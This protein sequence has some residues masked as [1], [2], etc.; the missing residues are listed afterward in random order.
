MKVINETHWR[1]DHLR[2]FILRVAK[3]ELPTDALPRTIVKVG[4][5]R[6][7]SG[8]A[9]RAR[10]PTTDERRDGLR[11]RIWLLL[12]PRSEPVVDRADLALV[13]AHEMAHCRGLR[14]GKDMRCPRYYRQPGYRERYAWATTLPLAARAL[15]V[16]R[17]KLRAQ[18]RDVRRA[19]AETMLQTWERKHKLATTMRAKWRAKVRRLTTE[20]TRAAAASKGGTSA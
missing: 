18:P 14:H 19:H 5:H 20:T 17:R 4:Y 9:G 10:Y 13:I 16:R 1:T 6:G 11:P 15:V 2:R 3:E 12:P 7:G 8:C